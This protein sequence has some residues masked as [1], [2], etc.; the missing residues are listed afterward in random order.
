MK[1]LL[2]AIL[3]ATALASPVSAE[4]YMVNCSNEDPSNNVTLVIDNTNQ[5]LSFA[6]QEGVSFRLTTTI[7]NDNYIGFQITR[8]INPVVNIQ[9]N[10]LLNRS[11][12]LMGATAVEFDED[13]QLTFENLQLH[14]TRG[15]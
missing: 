14:C 3:T 5:A 15:I 4:T 9:A 6:G 11:N 10:A 12:G 2:T 1:H 7:W 13:G 8:F